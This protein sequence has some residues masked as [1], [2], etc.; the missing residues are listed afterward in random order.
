MA[1][2]PNDTILCSGTFPFDAGLEQRI[3]AAAAAGFTALSLWM[4]DIARANASGLSDADIGAMLDHHGLQ[5]AELDPFWRWLPGS[6]IDVDPEHD[7]FGILQPT[8]ED[9][10]DV[11]DRFGAS[12][13]NA[14]DIISNPDWTVDDAAECFADLCDR[15]ADHGLRV[16]LEFLPWSRINDL[17]KAYEIVEQADR[18]NGGIMLDAW[19]F[20]RGTPDLDSLRNVPGDRLTGLQLNDAPAEPAPDLMTESMEARLL[21]GTGSFDLSGLRAVLKEIGAAAP[22]GVEVFS[23]EHNELAADEVAR[24]A[25]EALAALTSCE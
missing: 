10:L 21:P 23:A 22:V 18:P 12:S 16:H 17:A 5:I 1:L 11:A 4:R 3:E 24:R 20:F 13:L 9:F 6:A 8:L 2:G 25:G 14:C 19:H 7:E 15:A